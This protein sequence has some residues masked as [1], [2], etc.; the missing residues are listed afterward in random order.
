MIERPLPSNRRVGPRPS[1]AASAAAG[2]EGEAREPDGPRSSRRGGAGKP[3]PTPAKAARGASKAGAGSAPAGPPRRRWRFPVQKFLTAG[4][5]V[6]GTLL[7]FGLMAASTFGLYRYVSTSARFAI[8]QISIE[9]ASHLSE[10]EAGKLAGVSLGKNIF[11]VDLEQ[12]R[13]ALIQSPWVER[14]T[15]DRRLP[16]SIKITVVER[17]PAALV[18]L[19]GSLYLAAR[20]GD[21]FKRHTAGDPSDLVVITGVGGEG[22]MLRDRE[23]LVALVRRAQEVIGD[24][25]RLGPSRTYPL[26]E[27]HMTDEGGAS[28]IV[29]RDPVVLTLGR[30][31]Y[32]PK[33]ERGARV[34]AE[35][36]RRK[37]QPSVVF[38]DNDAHPE[39]VVARM[40]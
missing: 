30:A 38:L 10:A 24:Y 6:L 34:L 9:G 22:E 27:V 19:G 2:S 8:K 14:A 3:E 37:G 1:G 36:D 23:G 29:G 4:R 33:I 7:F 11:N 15:V 18:S 17:E 5:L 31:P 25:E 32:R 13:R 12:A 40:R 28:L 39:R 16:G 26:Q 35:I 21:V 20:G